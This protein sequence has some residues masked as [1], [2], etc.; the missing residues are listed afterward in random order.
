MKRQFIT[1]VE[2][3][4]AATTAEEINTKR[5]ELNNFVVGLR[6]VFDDVE[7]ELTAKNHFV[8]DVNNYVEQEDKAFYKRQLLMNVQG[9]VEIIREL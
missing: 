9:F 8:S 4:F 7:P 6:T 5:I 3:L 2:E 1:R